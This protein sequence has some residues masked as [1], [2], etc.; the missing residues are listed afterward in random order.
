[1]MKR[2]VVL[3][4]I[5]QNMSNKFGDIIIKHRQQRLNKVSVLSSS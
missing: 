3:S 4:S 1:M 5:A 2:G